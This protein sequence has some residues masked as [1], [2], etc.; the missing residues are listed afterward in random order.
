MNEIWMIIHKYSV[1]DEN[2]NRERHCIGPC[3]FDSEEEARA[4]KEKFIDYWRNLNNHQKRDM[5]EDMFHTGDKKVIFYPKRDI[6][7]Q[8]WKAQ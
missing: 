3:S 6:D 1:I 7:V 8:C 5:K 2:G 4:Y